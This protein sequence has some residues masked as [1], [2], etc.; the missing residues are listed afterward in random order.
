MY[1]IQNSPESIIK[2]H[3][4]AFQGLGL[5]REPVKPVKYCKWAMPIVPVTKKD[6]SLRISGDL[7]A[8]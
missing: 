6:D 8:Q 1:H 3:E 4:E 7:A 2:E 5:C